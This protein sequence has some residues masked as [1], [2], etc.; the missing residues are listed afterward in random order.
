[1]KIFQELNLA[2][3]APKKDKCDVRC[4]FEV[5]QIDKETYDRHIAKKNRAREE[6]NNEKGNL[7]KDKTVKVIRHHLLTMDVQ[8]VKISPCLYFSALYYKTKLNC[9]NFTVYNLSTHDG[10]F[11]WFKESEADLSADTFAS[12]AVHAI[13]EITKKEKLP[14]ILYS[15]GCTYQNRNS[16][17]SNALIHLSIELNIDIYQ[18]FLEKGHTQMECDLVHSTIEQSLKKKEIYLPSDYIKCTRDARTKPS[19]YNVFEVDH[20]FVKKYSETST[21]VSSSIRPGLSAGNP[22]VTNLRCLW[23]KPDGKMFYKLD[24]DEDQKLLPRRPKKV[25]FPIT[26]NLLHLDRLK[27]KPK[28]YQHLP[29]LKDVLP[30]D[31]HAF[32]DNLPH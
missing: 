12:C 16:I 31:C 3:Y 18:K 27:I 17:M 1:M 13:R 20:T 9:H 25:N 7:N 24:F 19:P 28:K 10:T 23:H 8:A 29:E 30:I 2:L 5:N 22:T 32:Y 4:S 26:F 11:Y 14:V 21:M 6:K 15:N